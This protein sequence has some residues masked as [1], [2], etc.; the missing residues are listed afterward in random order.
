MFQCDPESTPRWSKK[1]HKTIAIE[2]QRY[3]LEI[4]HQKPFREISV[5]EAVCLLSKV[6]PVSAHKL[7]DVKLTLNEG[8]V[9]KP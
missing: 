6:G 3:R 1:I 7:I 5:S 9:D 4:S 8:T 2:M